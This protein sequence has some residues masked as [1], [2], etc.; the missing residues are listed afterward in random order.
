MLPTDQMIKML[1][2]KM[3]GDL[4]ETREKGYIVVNYEQKV[5]NIKKRDIGAIFEEIH[6]NQTEINRI[7][8]EFNN[9]IYTETKLI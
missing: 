5:E 9:H 1:E 3:R 7:I 4:H 6:K 8:S 2:E